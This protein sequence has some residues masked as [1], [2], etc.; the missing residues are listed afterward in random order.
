MVT[1]EMMTVLEVFH[2]RIARRIA[3]MTLRN[4]NGGEWEWSLVDVS[5]NT[6]VLWPKREYVSRRQAK[7]DGIYIR[8]TNIQAVYM[9]RAD[10]GLQW[11]TKMVVPITQPLLDGERGTVK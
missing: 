10:G 3:E 4:G 11:V 1:D 8:E 2:H 9:I 5:L 6:T 7:I